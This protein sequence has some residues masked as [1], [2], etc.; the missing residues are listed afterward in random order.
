MRKVLRV[1]NDVKARRSRVKELMKLK[2]GELEMD[3]KL[4][5]IQELIPLEKGDVGSKA[6]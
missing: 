2:I 3:L 5:L 1:G 4:Q 6:T